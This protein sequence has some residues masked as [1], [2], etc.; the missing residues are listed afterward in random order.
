MR[1]QFQKTR[2]ET[3]LHEA[4]D[5]A[6]MLKWR[7]PDAGWGLIELEHWALSRCSDDAPPSSQA[8]VRGAAAAELVARVAGWRKAPEL[9]FDAA[10]QLPAGLARRVVDQGEACVDLAGLLRHYDEPWEKAR[11]ER[12]RKKKAR[13][14]EEAETNRD[15]SEDVRGRSAE[16]DGG[17][18]DSERKKKKE[19]EIENPL[20]SEEEVAP[21]EQ[22]PLEL[23]PSEPS[24]EHQEHPLQELWNRLAHPSLPRWEGMNPKRKK[25][26]DAR[27][28]DRSL[29]EHARVI[30]GINA[31]KFCLRMNERKWP[32]NPDWFLKP[33]TADKVL[34]G[35]YGRDA[36]PAPPP[37]E[38]GPVQPDT[39][40][41]RLWHDVLAKLRDDGH[42]YSLQ[43]LGKLHPVAIQGGALVLEVEDV[44]LAEWVGAT[45]GELLNATVSALGGATRVT[46]RPPVASEV[47]A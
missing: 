31:S 19:K 22:Q 37:P 12:D 21:A 32:A 23:E 2:S 30:E 3:L 8:L 14:E 28:K 44:F 29:A 20:P 13:D 26:A 42:E 15:A 43:W 17:S 36:A 16:G 47:A 40:A 6:V 45:Y 7:K 41:G 18:A 46:C 4:S 24:A 1:L 10:E 33:D 25:A 5:L 38:P 27:L 11:K 39:P 35:T 34:E 9:W